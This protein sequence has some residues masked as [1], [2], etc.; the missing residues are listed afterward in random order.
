FDKIALHP[1]L[2]MGKNMFGLSR[3]GSMKGNKSQTFQI[4]KS[5]FSGMVT[6]QI[7]QLIESSQKSSCRSF[8]NGI[9]LSVLKDQHGF[10]FYPPG[11]FWCFP[12]VFYH[13]FMGFGKTKLIHRTGLA[14]GRSVRDTD[15]SPKL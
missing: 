1:P 2:H 10:L 15:C 13:F 5:F 8:M 3:T 4:S 12:G 6:L 7:R 14:S 9:F 11:F